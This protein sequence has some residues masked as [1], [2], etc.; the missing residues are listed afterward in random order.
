MLLAAAKPRLAGEALDCQVKTGP[1]GFQSI[2]CIIGGAVI[3]QD[4]FKVRQAL[5]RK[6]GETGGYMRLIVP[7]NH[8]DGEERSARHDPIIRGESFTLDF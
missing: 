5:L 1:A 3:H 4:H 6:H 2:R 8:D 7:G